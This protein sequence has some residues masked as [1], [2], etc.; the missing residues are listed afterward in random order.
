MQGY[1][2][3]FLSDHIVQLT[4]VFLL[5]TTGSCQFSDK[6]K[7]QLSC[8][9]QINLFGYWLVY[10]EKGIDNVFIFKDSLSAQNQARVA[11]T[12]MRV[13]QPQNNSYEFN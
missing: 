9:S 3:P 6:P 1:A 12:I 5:T 2:F 13:Q 10:D 8:A 7:Q 4:Q 11:R